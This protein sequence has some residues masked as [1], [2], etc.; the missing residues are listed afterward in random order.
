[1]LGGRITVGATL[2][3]GTRMTGTITFALYGPGDPACAR[4]LAR[5]TAPVS[6]AGLYAAAPAPAGAAGTYRW[7]ATYSGDP[8][9]DAAGPT[10]CGA[11]T[12]AVTARS[13]VFHLGPP[14]ADARGR[15]LV[16]LRAPGPGRFTASAT[17]GATRFGAAAVTLRAAGPTHLLIAPSAHLRRRTRVRVT[18]AITFSPIGGR[19]RTRTVHL[20]V[21]RIP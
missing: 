20:A 7:T 13:N 5:S 4:P 15:I 17:A 9:N 3:G 18:L 1:V 11:A 16:P 21:R 19:P 14:R 8:D 2:A 10:A 6:G 12:V